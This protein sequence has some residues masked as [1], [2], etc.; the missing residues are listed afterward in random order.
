MPWGVGYALNTNQ[1]L[2]ELPM[3]TP[4]LGCV[5]EEPRT[6]QLDIQRRACISMLNNVLKEQVKE[7]YL[8]ASWNSEYQTL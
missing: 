7:L 6:D 2:E 1:F 3:N 5:V 4:K 8:I